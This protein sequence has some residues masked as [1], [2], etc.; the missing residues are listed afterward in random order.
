ME[1]DEVYLE[2]PVLNND[3]EITHKHIE[4][5]YAYEFYH[6]LRVAFG[7]SGYIING[8]PVKSTNSIYY[9]TSKIPDFIIHK[10]GSH[11]NLAVI[12]LKS[13][14]NKNLV[15][16]N[17]DVE[18]A[19]E[20]KSDL[21]YEISIF[22]CFG[23]TALSEEAKDQLMRGFNLIIHHKSENQIQGFLYSPEKEAL[24]QLHPNSQ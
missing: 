6:Q 8:E 5:V 4:R 2:Q 20:F 16:F 7:N 9:Q 13:A 22:I 21:N 17:K 10:P 15:S 3:Q 1:M 19:L 11:K 23:N 14:F 24:I 18:T 12:E